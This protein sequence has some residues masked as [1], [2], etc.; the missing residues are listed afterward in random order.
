[1]ASIFRKSSGPCD[2]GLPAFQDRCVQSGVHRFDQTRP[3][4]VIHLVTFGSLPFVFLAASSY[5]NEW[6][7]SNRNFQA[8]SSL[9]VKLSEDHSSC[10]V[11]LQSAPA[12][13]RFAQPIDL[14]TV[15]T[16]FLSEQISSFSLKTKFIFFIVAAHY[17]LINISHALGDLSI[18]GWESLSL[19]TY[20]DVV[21]HANKTDWMFDPVF[22]HI[23]LSHS[24]LQ[25]GCRL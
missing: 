19:A 13:Q 10:L 5:N 4:F 9:A 3:A 1:M 25:W 23:K 16:S 14:H 12:R 11:L 8:A 20:N 15:W 7:T 18:Q 22:W 6:M 17:T 24:F 2:S 21:F